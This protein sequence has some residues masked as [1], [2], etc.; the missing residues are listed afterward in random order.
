MSQD[1]T[2]LTKEQILTADDLPTQEVDVTAWGGH[3]RI[4]TLRGYER[5]AFEQ[6]IQNRKKG[7]QYNLLG[8]KVEFLQIVLVDEEGNAL[9]EKADLKALNEKSSMPINQLFDVASKMSGITEKDVD[10]LQQNL[11]DAPS[12]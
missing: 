5:D 4:R 9:F 12:G 11:G 2:F 7:D 3:V 10:E 8:I 1:K 6:K